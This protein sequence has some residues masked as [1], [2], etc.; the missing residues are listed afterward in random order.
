[1]RH[2]VYLAYSSCKRYYVGV[3]S[4]VDMEDFNRYPTSSSDECFKKNLLWKKVLS[5]HPTRLD[6]ENEECRILV[7]LDAKNHPLMANRHNSDGKFSYCK[8]GKENHFYGK[9]HSDETK[10][11]ISEANRSSTLFLWH[12]E[13]GTEITATVNSMVKKYDLHRGALWGLITLGFCKHAM[14]SFKGWRV[15]EFLDLK[16][17]YSLIKTRQ[18]Q[19]KSRVRKYYPYLWVH[20]EGGTHYGTAYTLAKKLKALPKAVLRLTSESNYR[21]LKQDGNFHRAKCRY[22]GWAPTCP[23]D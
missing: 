11:K 17:E 16:G 14:Y 7:A 19:E 1:M 4:S 23:L 6:A 8:F 9:G 12:H 20:Y 10:N 5:E 13:D 22:K 15:S 18:L 3:R 2:F 21:R